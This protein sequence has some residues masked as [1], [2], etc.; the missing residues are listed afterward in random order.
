VIVLQNRESSSGLSAAQPADRE[1]R[2]DELRRAQ[3]EAAHARRALEHTTNLARYVE[4]LAGKFPLRDNQALR[5]QMRRAA[6]DALSH[7]ACAVETENAADY[8]SF[9][10]RSLSALNELDTFARLGSK[11]GGVT[12]TEAGHLAVM[13]QMVEVSLRCAL[14]DSPFVSFTVVDTTRAA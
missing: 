3:A 9:L 7:A 14:D 1:T 10:M 13:A 11:S 5:S 6:G 2:D 4:Q 12:A 8:R